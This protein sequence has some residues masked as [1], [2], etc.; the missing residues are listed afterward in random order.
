MI[1]SVILVIHVLLAITIVVGFA[2]RYALAFKKREYPTEAKK[3][4]FGGL[5]GLIG[6]GTLL[7][8]VAKLPITSVCLD[9][10]GLIVAFLVMEVGLQKMS[11]RLATEKNKINKR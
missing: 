11:A 6:T 9:S 10:L 8:V 2:Y 7:A 3:I 5:A 1:V 4:V